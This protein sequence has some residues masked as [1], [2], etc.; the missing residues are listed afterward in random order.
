MK[1]IRCVTLT[2]L[3]GTMTMVLFASSAPSDQKQ[4]HSQ[5][6]LQSKGKLG[7]DVAILSS[8]CIKI[9]PGPDFVVEVPVDEHGNP[10]FDNSKMT[11][12]VGYKVDP[13]AK[14]CTIRMERRKTS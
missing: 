13:D 8:A 4:S 1:C 9:I 6:K 7:G 2:L 14:G 5:P 10:D 11:G 12:S 3:I